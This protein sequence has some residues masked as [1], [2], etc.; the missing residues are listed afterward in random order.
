MLITK[1]SST[2][3]AAERRAST[4]LG[5]QVSS[6]LHELN[7][8]R[9]ETKRLLDHRR[10]MEIHL[11][12]LRAE[13][14]QLRAERVKLVAGTTPAPAAEN[15]EVPHDVDLV[16]PSRPIE[17]PEPRSGRITPPSDE[18]E[19]AFSA[20]LRAD[21]DHDKSREWFLSDVGGS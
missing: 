8:V 17:T 3:L 16:Q 20:F 12:A 14:E 21:I 13:L 11:V 2:R 18:D 4:D 5:K 7:S 1:E 15:V 9:D 19:D 10:Q 6:V